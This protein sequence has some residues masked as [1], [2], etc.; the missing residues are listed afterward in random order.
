MVII[1][2]IHPS[3]TACRL[4]L[5]AKPCTNSTITMLKMIVSGGGCFRLAQVSHAVMTGRE[6]VWEETKSDGG[7]DLLEGVR[8]INRMEID[9]IHYYKEHRA[10]GMSGIVF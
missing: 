3:T 4:A 9:K 5:L 8:N 10:V 1:D 6:G 2:I 7:G